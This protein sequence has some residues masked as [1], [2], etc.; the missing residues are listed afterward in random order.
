MKS[1]TIFPHCLSREANLLE[2]LSFILSLYSY[3]IINSPQRNIFR[4]GMI[5]KSASDESLVDVYCKANQYLHHHG[6][7]QTLVDSGAI[8][9]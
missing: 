7:E 2:I 9:A 4:S 3:H 8:V 1:S 5:S 6:A